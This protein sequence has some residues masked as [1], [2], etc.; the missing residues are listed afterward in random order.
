MWLVIVSPSI[1]QSPT[2]RVTEAEHW[3]GRSLYASILILLFI[4]SRC[5][6][7]WPVWLQPMKV[8]RVSEREGEKERERWA[9]QPSTAQVKNWIT[10]KQ[11]KIG[12]TSCARHPTTLQTPT[13]YISC[14]RWSPMY[15][16]C[17]LAPNVTRSH[18]LPIEC[19][20]TLVTHTHTHIYKW[21]HSFIYIDRRNVV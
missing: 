9:E 4:R 10:D 18:C 13:S 21:I 20:I 16:G 7:I 12:Q 14:A 11:D 5:T 17:Q 8:E 19:S 2:P 1:E 15:P 6:L 3:I